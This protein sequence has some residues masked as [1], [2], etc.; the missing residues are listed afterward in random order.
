M[1]LSSMP[2]L[3]AS[4]LTYFKNGLANFFTLQQ[5]KVAFVAMAIFSAFTSGIYLY[6]HYFRMRQVSHLI[7]NIDVNRTIMAD[8][9]K[10]GFNLQDILAMILAE[11]YQAKWN[12][13]ELSFLEYVSSLIPGS[14]NGPIK[15]QRQAILKDFVYLLQHSAFQEESTIDFK[16]LKEHPT[17][18]IEQIKQKLNQVK[19]QVLADIKKLQQTNEKGF[20][21]LKENIMRDYKRMEE[22]LANQPYFIFPSYFR[23]IAW[24]REKKE[25]NFHIILRTFGDDGQK[26]VSETEKA[27]PEEKFTHKGKYRAGEW[28][29]SLMDDSQP[30]LMSKVKEVY[31]YFKSQNY[32]HLALQDDW[33]EW[34][35]NQE[36]QDH[37]KRF[38]LKRNAKR[39]HIVFIDDNIEKESQTSKNIVTPLD[40]ESGQTIPI[41]SLIAKKI[42]V[43]T[44]TMKAILDDEYLIK[45]VQESLKLNGKRV[46]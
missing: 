10:A 27:F 23:L 33:K 24:L 12:G 1:F 37:G 6:R 11:N 15:K 44:E 35:A 20:A 43:R 19:S 39:T 16:K 28:H 17:E 38:L 2:A 32:R 30:C 36:H 7:L 45:V 9:P 21:Q 26:I 18:D 31:R 46:V 3:M 42:A 34:S 40:V 8:D 41:N 13:Q 5:K 4:S 14:H 25:V 29:L 22:K